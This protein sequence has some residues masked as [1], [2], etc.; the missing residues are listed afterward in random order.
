MLGRRYVYLSVTLFYACTRG[1]QGRVRGIYTL[2]DMFVI[3]RMAE[4]KLHDQRQLTQSVTQC[5]L[6]HEVYDCALFVYL[7][8]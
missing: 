4:V 5:Y 7:V 1:W 8:I 6:L 2:H 3:A